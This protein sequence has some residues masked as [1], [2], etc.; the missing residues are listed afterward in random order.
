MESLGVLHNGDLRDL[1]TSRATVRLCSEIN[2]IM[3]GCTSSSERKIN[4]HRILMRKFTRR[5]NIRTTLRYKIRGSHSGGHDEL[6]LLICNAV[7]G[8]AVKYYAT[9]RK[10]AG[11]I[12][13]EVIAFVN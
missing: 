4:A 2:K 13:N 6:Y 11:S 8:H 12:P 3:N 5:K 10:V 1:C 9:S 7:R